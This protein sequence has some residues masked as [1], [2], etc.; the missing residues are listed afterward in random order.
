[1][2]FDE[3]VPGEIGDRVILEVLGYSQPTPG[4]PWI[5]ANGKVQ[6]SDLDSPTPSQELSDAFWACEMIGI[7]YS[8]SKGTKK[9]LLIG[10]PFRRVYW[11]VFNVK[12]FP[13]EAP[14][15]E[16]ETLGGAVL[17]SFIFLR[18]LAKANDNPPSRIIH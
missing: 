13:M 1:M 3:A 6:N 7:D 15:L 14:D 10:G 2:R 11:V 4:G 16:S 12:D 5:D 17:K 18:D 9:P 8:I